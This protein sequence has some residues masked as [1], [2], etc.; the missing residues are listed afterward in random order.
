MG[1]TSPGAVTVDLSSGLT[2][3]LMAVTSGCSLPFAKML[4]TTIIAKTAT[5]ATAITTFF[6]RLI[7]IS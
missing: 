2:S 1:R 4:M 6:F 7:A 5:A 3:T